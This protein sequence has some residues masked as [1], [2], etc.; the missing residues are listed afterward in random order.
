MIGMNRRNTPRGQMS[1]GKG[2]PAIQ[3]MEGC[4]WNRLACFGFIV[5]W[6]FFAATHPLSCLSCVVFPVRMVAVSVFGIYKQQ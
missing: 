3:M 5:D 4:E 6:P 1:M 2:G